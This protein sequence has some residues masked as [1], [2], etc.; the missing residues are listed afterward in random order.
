M[1]KRV[2]DSFFEVVIKYRTQEIKGKAGDMW[3]TRMSD[4]E[5]GT[6][7]CR[8]GKALIISEEEERNQK[9]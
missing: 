6:C 3:R 1:F 7:R 8:G 2:R 4:R 5:N 9:G